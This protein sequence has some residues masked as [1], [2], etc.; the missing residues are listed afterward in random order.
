MTGSFYVRQGPGFEYDLLGMVL[1]RGQA[2]EVVAVYGDWLQARWTPQ[3]GAEVVG[4]V[5]MRWVGTLTPFPGRIITP[6]AT[7]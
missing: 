2:I 7:P 1:S 3:D 6:T 5:L 4:W